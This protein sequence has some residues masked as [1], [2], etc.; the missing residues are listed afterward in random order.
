MT[1]SQSIASLCLLLFSTHT[2]LL[3]A[4]LTFGIVGKSVDDGN[5]IDA[6]QGCADEAK[7]FG[8]QCLHLGGRGPSQPRMQAQAIE[9][10]LASKQFDAL[11]ISVTSSRFIAKAV[12]N[13]SMPIFTFDSP[14]AAAESHL[15]RA[16][17][18]TDNLAFG[19]ALAKIARQLRPQGGSVCIITAMHDPNLQQRVRGVRQELSGDPALSGEQNLAGEGGWSETRRCPWN[20]ADDPNHT[21]NA[22]SITFNQLQP[23]VIIS[24]GHWPVLDAQAYRKTV[25]PVQ[26]A[27]QQKQ[28]IVIVGVGKIHPPQAALLR[29]KLVH[30][31][32]SID[33][34][35]MGKLTYQVMKAAKEG[36]PF[37]PITY[38]PDLSSIAP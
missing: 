1:L 24:V 8:D 14:F 7:R 33:F 26:Q 22:L 32:V 3:A 18:G 5:F 11:A 37:A 25:Q 38:T 9:E 19:R 12:G 20:S 29:D 13:A 28:R 31:Y 15:S 27:L 34:P 21:M 30:G 4:G 16:Y 35:K 23:D 2:T 36:R 10:A 6:W 17:I